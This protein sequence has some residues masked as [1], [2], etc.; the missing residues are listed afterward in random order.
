MHSDFIFGNNFISEYLPMTIK[1][2]SIDLTFKQSSHA[3]PSITITENINVTQDS[4][5]YQSRISP[6]I[7]AQDEKYWLYA[8]LFLQSVYFLLRKIA[9][10]IHLFG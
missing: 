8:I 7:N 4:L 5:L 1:S 3:H 6:I 9:F 10:I 2:G